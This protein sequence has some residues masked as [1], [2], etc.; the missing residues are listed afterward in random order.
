MST[1]LAQPDFSPAFGQLQNLYFQQLNGPTGSEFS[2][3]P[4]ESVTPPHSRGIPSACPMPKPALEPT[5]RFGFADV[6]GRACFV[7]QNPAVCNGSKTLRLNTVVRDSFSQNTF[8]DKDDDTHFLCF[9]QVYSQAASGQ[10]M[11]KLETILQ[12]NA[13]TRPKVA[14]WSFS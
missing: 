2:H 6:S 10:L 5:R 12:Q 1:A 14:E 4:W 11:Q 3:R 9:S 8:S 13:R 7:R